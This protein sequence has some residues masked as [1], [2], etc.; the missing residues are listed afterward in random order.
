[1][2][3]SP[4]IRHTTILF[5]NVK[6]NPIR[7]N[8]ARI[9]AREMVD[10]ILIAESPYWNRPEDLLQTVNREFAAMSFRGIRPTFRHISA[11]NVNRRVQVFSHIHPSQWQLL[12]EREF[13]AIWR[14]K[15]RARN[16][17]L[18]TAAHFPP[19]QL[20][21]GDGQRYAANLLRRDLEGVEGRYSRDD[22]TNYARDRIGF[23]GAPTLV[24][25]DLNASPFEAGIAA[26][27]ALN[28]VPWRP[29]ARKGTRHVS[30]EYHPYFYNP[31]WRLMGVQDTDTDK[32]PGTYYYDNQ[33]KPVW[34]GWYTLDQVLIRPRLLPYMSDGDVRVLLNDGVS[35]L[36]KRGE[37]RPRREISD[38]LPL[39]VRIAQ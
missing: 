21:E 35:S 12:Q 23:K 20:D 18:L 39:V 38:H 27:Y 29:I 16:T 14:L 33:D 22:V 36:V 30:N 26:S 24:I 31:M 34:F 6:K 8:I 5:W 1:M 3:V 25:G 19:M 4:A 2:P 15:T 11:T 37:R 10:V 28:A 7:E 13:H 9:V 17:L 32:S